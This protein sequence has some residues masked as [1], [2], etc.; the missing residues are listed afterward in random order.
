MRKLIYILLLT[1]L[2]TACSQVKNQPTPTKSP[3]VTSSISGDTVVL[4]LKKND[5]S[6]LQVTFSEIQA[7]PQ[8]TETLYEKEES[9]VRL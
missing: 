2:L 5:G 3:Q 9:G 7:L 8:V 1:F 4:K 6:V